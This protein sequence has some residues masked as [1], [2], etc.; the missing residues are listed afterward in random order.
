[1]KYY[2]ISENDMKN[3]AEAIRDKK[4][5]TDGM[6]ISQM[7]EEIASIE[8]VRYVTFMLGNVELYRKAVVVGDN[9]IDV[10]NEG[11]IEAPTKESNAQ[12]DYTFYGWG[13][14]DGGAADDTI[15]HNITKDTTVYAIFT[16]TVKTYTIT[17]LDD[18]GVTVLGM[19]QVPYDTIPSY[20]PTKTGYMFAGWNPVPVP[21]TGDAS[22]SATWSEFITILNT[23]KITI[24]SYNYQGG[25]SV[26]SYSYAAGDIFVVEWD[27][28]TYNVPVQYARFYYPNGES[29]SNKFYGI[30]NPYKKITTSGNQ[31]NRV[32][33]GST[34]AQIAD[35][36]TLPFWIEFSSSY[37]TFYAGTNMGT[38]NVKIVKLA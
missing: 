32:V 2:A 1:M 27:G 10:V 14:S 7:P 12:Y 19:E 26:T 9:C 37:L 22:Y 11:I 36:S 31:T 20:T 33:N 30:G 28:E 8:T 6:L 13:A 4:R 29:N 18:D 35:D 16:A 21:V 5:Q 38:Y 17:W 3:I 23:K 34:N 24:S 25:T 15:L